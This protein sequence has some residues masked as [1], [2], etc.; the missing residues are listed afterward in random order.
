MSLFSFGTGLMTTVKR[1][2]YF[3]SFDGV[4]DY[5][6]A[7][8]ASVFDVTTGDFDMEVT[9]RS[10]YS[11]NNP[12]RII[13]KRGTGA[14]ATGYPSYQLS[15]VNGNYQNTNIQYVGSSR[16][17]GGVGSGFDL[18]DF[19]HDNEW[20]KVKFT[21]QN[22]VGEA[23]LFID[24]SEVASSTNANFIG[25]SLTTTRKFTVGGS[26]NNDGQFF[27]GDIYSFRFG[28]ET[29]PLNEGTGTTITGSEG[30]VLD[31]YGATWG[32]EIQ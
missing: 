23:K 29:F 9:Y 5:V 11:G 13:D 30:T 20:H 19:E 21:F 2:E 24:G 26:S 28:N 17:I 15:G 10:G 16:S 27:D 7:Q 22:S 25:K 12:F 1:V 4:D 8:N 6:Q 31:I 18:V 3:L 32:S 14:I